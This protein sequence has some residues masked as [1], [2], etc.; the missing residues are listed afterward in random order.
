MQPGTLSH[1]IGHDT[2]LGLG[3]G[4]RDDGLPLGRPRDKRR[5]EVDA[6][7]GSRAS[8]VG[9]ACPIRVRVGDDV[10]RWRGGD[11]E[12]ELHGAANVPEDPLDSGPVGITRRMHVEAHLL[13][14]IL[15]LRPSERQVLK[16][17]DDGAVKRLILKRRTIGG[18]ELGL[19][20][21]G[22]GRSVTPR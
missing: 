4:P 3:A 20:V 17:A 5:A 6:V 16:G 14:R 2:I 12:A 9:A 21:D 13:N 10:R 1:C 18:G 8:S 19:R 11:G 7:A 15:K 22:S